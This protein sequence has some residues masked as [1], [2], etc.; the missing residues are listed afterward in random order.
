MSVPW[1]NMCCTVS[2]FIEIVTHA[3]ASQYI[4]IASLCIFTS[5]VSHICVHSNTFMLLL[6]L[7]GKCVMTLSVRHDGVYI[8]HDIYI[9]ASLSLEYIHCD[10]A[11]TC[12]CIFFFPFMWR[13]DRGGVGGVFFFLFFFPRF[14]TTLSLSLFL[15]LSLLYLSHW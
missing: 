9:C 5:V 7:H 12:F 8:R 3:V 14:S 4:C 1:R 6:H 10:Q 11:N 13:T 2:V 15:S